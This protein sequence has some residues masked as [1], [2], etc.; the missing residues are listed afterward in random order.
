MPLVC[1]SLSHDAKVKRKYFSSVDY[2][3]HRNT[4]RHLLKLPL[5]VISLQTHIPISSLCDIV[6]S[7]RHKQKSYTNSS[8]STRTQHKEELH[9]VRTQMTRESV[10]SDRFK[11]ICAVERFSSSQSALALPHMETIRSK[12]THSR[13]HILRG[14]RTLSENNV[15]KHS[16]KY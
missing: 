3:S 1:A 11:P 2:Y 9:R 14:K 5:H 13:S 4:K 12:R 8:F 15:Q 16:T 10:C 7:R 6:A